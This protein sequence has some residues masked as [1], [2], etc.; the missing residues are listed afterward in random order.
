MNITM[1]WSSKVISE[2]VTNWITFS[3]EKKMETYWIYSTLILAFGEREIAEKASPDMRIVEGHGLFGQKSITL[4]STV[5]VISL[6][7]LL[8]PLKHLN[9]YR[10]PHAAPLSHSPSPTATNKFPGGNWSCR[11]PPHL[12]AAIKR[13]NLLLHAFFFVY[14]HRFHIQNHYFH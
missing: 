4:T 11:F 13:T 3:W 1:S 10:L 12:V 9:L 2:I 7:G 14:L 8:L 5:V 6:H